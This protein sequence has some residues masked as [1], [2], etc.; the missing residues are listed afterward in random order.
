[1]ATHLLDNQNITF[2][3]FKFLNSTKYLPFPL[4]LSIPARLS[5]SFFFIIELIL[6]IYLRKTIFDYLKSPETKLGPINY[7][8]WLDQVNG[9]FLGVAISLRLIAMCTPTPLADI[10][11]PVGCEWLGLPVCIYLCGGVAWSSFIGIYR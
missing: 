6:G 8:I 11:G 9:L 7:L 2:I 1:M 10:I 4:N 5:I 3:Y